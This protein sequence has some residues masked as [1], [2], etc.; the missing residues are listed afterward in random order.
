MTLPLQATI[1]TRTPLSTASV[2]DRMTVEGRSALIGL[3]WAAWYSSR[4]DAARDL[5][6]GIASEDA[7]AAARAAGATTEASLKLLRLRRVASGDAD[8]KA[9]VDA[10]LAGTP[11][12]HAPV[13]LR[14]VM[15]AT[16]A[17]RR[18]MLDR[19]R[20]EIALLPLEDATVIAAVIAYLVGT[21]VDYAQAI[22]CE[23]P[24]ARGSTRSVLQALGLPALTY[25]PRMRSWL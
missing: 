15:E 22:V 13:R 11:V 8:V 10:L 14:R 6:S 18:R 23:S 3:A 17:D 16:D 21:E 20:A 1:R 5:L 24:M 7:V 19:A 12:L 25:M 2:L 4:S 9:I